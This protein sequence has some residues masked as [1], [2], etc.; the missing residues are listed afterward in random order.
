MCNNEGASPPATGDADPPAGDRLVI[1]EWGTFTCLQDETGRAIWGVNT[2]DE[3]VPEFVHRISELIPHPSE[4]APVYYKGVPRSHREVR[5]RLETPVLYFYPP[6]G[7]TAPLH[8]SVKVGFRGGWLTEYYPDAQVSAPGL[9]EGD[10]RYGRITP[11]TV[12]SLHWHDLTIGGDGGRL[13]QTN[14]PVWLAPRQVRAATVRVPGGEAEKYLFYR[15]VG[16][17]SSPVTVTR[18]SAGDGVVI[19][20]NVDSRLNLPAPLAL[21][22]MWLVHVRD[23]GT[24]AYSALGSAELTGQRDRVLARAALNFEPLP[25][26]PRDKSES[27]AIARSPESLF[28]EYS[29]NKLDA[30]RLEMRKALIADGLFAD[31]ADAMLKTWELAYFKSPGLR[32][33]YLLPQAWTDAVLPLQCSLPADVSRTMVGRVEIVTPRQRELLRQI[34]RGP[35]SNS[36]WFFRNIEQGANRGA[37]LNQLWLGKVR[38]SDLKLSVPDDYKAYL[39]LGRFRNALILDAQVRDPGCGLHRFS[40]PYHIEY[41]TPADDGVPTAGTR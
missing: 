7:S 28:D 41:Y 16:N 11:Q 6:A 26:G 8:A 10:F 17:I 34:G 35:V 9:Q 13:P 3:A 14:A 5:M 23:D 37:A 40:E 36:D 18:D 30:L 19:R 15:G 20:E 31:E 25:A 4:L 2:D 21:S 32:L 33:F 24:V 1:H 12:G 29:A 38:L 27:G 39:D 22:A